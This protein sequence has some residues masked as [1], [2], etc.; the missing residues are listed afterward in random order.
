MFEDLGVVDISEAS[1]V[2]VGK[3]HVSHCKMQ[4]AVTA[5]LSCLEGEP[6]PESH[7]EA[8]YRSCTVSAIL[9]E[10]VYQV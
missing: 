10:H 4:Q 5:V 1:L 7:S 9:H 6:H 3:N 8:E 2:I